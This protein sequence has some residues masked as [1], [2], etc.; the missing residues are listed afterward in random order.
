[1][2]TRDH[3]ISSAGPGTQQSSEHLGEAAY[4]AIFE[5]LDQGFCIVE[6]LFDDRQAPADCRFL[7]TNASFRRLTGLDDPIG[8]TTKAL[9]HVRHWFDICGRVA[10]TGEP[11]RFEDRAEA[12]G[13]RWYDIHMVRIGAARKRHVAIF[14]N[15]ITAQKQAEDALKESEL[16]ARSLIE[17]ISQALW[18]T[19]ADG[20]VV[21]D[22]PSWRAYTGQTLEQ[23][24]R[25]GWINAIHPDDRAHVQHQWHETVIARRRLDT[26]FRLWHA[27]SNDWRWTNVRAAPLT[28]EDGSIRKWVG[29]NID[30][31]ERHLAEESLRKSE[32]NLREFGK[33]SQDI[34]WIRDAETLQWVYL[35]PAFETIYGLARDEAL[36]GDNFRS[37]LDLVHPDDR[38]RVKRSVERIRGGEHLDFDYRICRPD[39]GVR[40]MQNSDFPIRDDAGHVAL[41]GGIGHDMTELHEAELRLHTLIEGIPQ[42]V[43]RAA[44]GGGWAWSSPQWTSFTGLSAEET[45][46][47]GWLLALH[48]D[49]RER[50]MHLWDAAIGS[51][52]LEMEARICHAESQRYRWFQT[53]ATPVRDEGGTIIE[54]L[55][56]CT[57]IHDMRDLQEHQHVLVA[58]LQHRTRNLMAVVRSMADKTARSSSDLPDFRLRFRDRLEALARVQGL[59][60]RLTDHDRVTFD[61]LIAAEL[62]AMDGAAERVITEG[63]AGIR[64]RSSTVQTLAMALHELATNAMKY[65]ALGQADGNLRITWSFEPCG[66]EGKPWLHIDWQESSVD[67]PLPGAAAQGTGQG[68]ELIEQA[69]PYQLKARTRYELTPDGVHCAISVPVSQTTGNGEMEDA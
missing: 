32:E 20:V 41:I 8:R 63:P 59:L 66:A 17:G 13:N 44:G 5:K 6:V 21:A 42:L 24:L 14:L 30:I 50:A 37:W 7:D 1:M 49:D 48:P 64:L 27:A 19:D 54:W 12:F 33:A 10:L 39:G 47:A 56:T 45:L 36:S 18:E 65:G 61:E 67:M 68:R 25:G 58:E 43:W 62:T 31:H 16:R 60:S 15:D 52:H 69:L 23:W 35:T 2:M 40:W 46:G 3:D 57:D 28:D 55:G 51:G 29:V 38:E 4:R 22:S 11:F 9:G 34:L 53:R 26:E